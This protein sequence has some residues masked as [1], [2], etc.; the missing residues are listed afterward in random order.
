M[1]K[2]HTPLSTLFKKGG[3]L[4][5]AIPNDPVILLSNVNTQLRDKYPSLD[6]FGKSNSIDISEIKNKLSAIGY[7]YSA[8]LNRFI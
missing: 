5:M 8:E 6:E 2:L 3:K 7:E 4:E 1:R